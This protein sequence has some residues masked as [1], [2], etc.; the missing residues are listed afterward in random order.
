[1]PVIRSERK[2]FLRAVLWQYGG[3]MFGSRD[4]QILLVEPDAAEAGRATATLKR[5]KVRN[6]VTVAADAGQALAHLRREANH[7][8]S[9]RPNLILLSA[10]SLEQ[11]G[12]E[13]LA[14]IKADA[15]LS[16]IPVVFLSN[17]EADANV[18]RAYDLAANCY[19]HKPVSEEELEHVLETTREF[20][21]SIVKLPID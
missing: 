18:T 16:H 9:P 4:I 13:L 6:H 14:A 10:D 11:R 21:L 3:K 8:R 5:A 12:E 17:S 15:R 20:W 7:Y 19:V 1:M 2:A